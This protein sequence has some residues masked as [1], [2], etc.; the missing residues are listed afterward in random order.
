MV[1]GYRAGAFCEPPEWGSRGPRSD[2]APLRRCPATRAIAEVDRGANGLEFGQQKY[3]DTRRAGGEPTVDMHPD[4]T[5]LYGAHAGTTHFYAPEA[6]DQD[7]TAFVNNYEGQTYYWW[8]DDLGDTW[9][10]VSSLR[11]VG[12]VSFHCG[13]IRP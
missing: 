9:H 5:L 3:I 6:A 10:F 7:S 13:F 4:G 2:W 11:L 12:S 8:S 1:D